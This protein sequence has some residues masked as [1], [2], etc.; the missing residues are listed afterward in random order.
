MAEPE[1]VRKWGMIGGGVV[2]VILLIAVA[3][4]LA[5]RNSD[6]KDAASTDTSSTT[7]STVAATTTAAASATTAATTTTPPTTAAPTTTSA[8]AGTD[9]T[10]VDWK[11]RAYPVTCGM[12]DD[13]KLVDGEAKATSDLSDGGIDGFH[14]SYGDVTS[15]PGNEAIVSFNCHTGNNNFSGNILVYESSASGPVLV[16]LP[17]A[18]ADQYSSTAVPKVVDGVITTLDPH[19]GND[20][21]HC[22]PSSQVT[23]YWHVVNGTWTPSTT[24]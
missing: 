8:P 23:H 1:Q 14:V 12:L 9:L 10:A 13:P 22:C 15:G 20:D 5:Q 4:L 24:P 6:D 7:S 2:I 18:F 21:P 19:W 3:V 16:G 17:F 11:N